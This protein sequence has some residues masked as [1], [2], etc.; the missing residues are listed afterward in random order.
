MLMGKT[1]CGNQNPVR[2]VI[3]KVINYFKIFVVPLV[4]LFMTW[5]GVYLLVVRTKEEEYNKR[6]NEVLAIFMGLVIIALAVTIVDQLF[7]GV[8]G[9]VFT[10]NL[11]GTF[12]QAVLLQIHGLVRFLLSFVVPIALL[13]VVI[14]AFQ[15][16]FG[17][18]DDES[19]GKLKRRILYIIIGII[20]ILIADPLVRSFADP[21]GIGRPDVF[22]L[23]SIGTGWINYLFGF[24]TVLGIFAIVWAGV[25][26]IIHFGDE[27]RV[28]S[29]K[30]TIKY[31]IIGLLVVFSAWT[32]VRF[33]LTAGI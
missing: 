3:E 17:G 5:A 33:F 1:A 32:L 7:F 9:E 2:C 29:A 23:L 22:Q 10:Q 18:G 11:E 24:I 31:V 8:R 19:M 21:T 6:K 16:I 27:E 4:V 13:I 28:E 15:L 26:M 20:V 25:M 12:A 30:N 14:S